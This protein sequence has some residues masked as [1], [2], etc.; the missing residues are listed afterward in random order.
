MK[1]LQYI[2]FI[3]CFVLLNSCKYG[4]DFEVLNNHQ[5]NI[6]SLIITNGFN[7]LKFNTIKFNESKKGFLDFKKNSPKHDGQY[8]IQLF[9]KDIVKRKAFGYYSNGGPINSFYKISI[10]KDTIIISEK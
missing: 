5:S 1:L 4:V 2:S 3:S 10:Q 8:I 9:L 6:D 7:S